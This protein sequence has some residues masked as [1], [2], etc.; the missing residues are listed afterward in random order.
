MKVTIRPTKTIHVQKQI[1]RW[2]LVLLT[3]FIYSP[4][5]AINFNQTS[6]KGMAQAYGFVLAQEY[7]LSRITK[8]FPDLALNVQL[9]RAQFDSI[10]PDI[11]IKLAAQLA[12]AMGEKTFQETDR[13]L[14]IKLYGIV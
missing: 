7:S 3:F 4:S 6:M 12:Q 2:M 11:K 10:F 5:F 1:S 14:R 8:E 13:K 9:A